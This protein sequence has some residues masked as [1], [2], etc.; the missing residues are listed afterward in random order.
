MT[1]TQKIMLTARTALYGDMEASAE[2]AHDLGV[3]PRTVRNW[4]AGKNDVPPE[5]LQRVDA[6][7]TARSRVLK[8]AHSQIVALTIVRPSS[9]A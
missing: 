4:I 2:F 7:L 3:N 9:G 5:V 6:L 8:D 1:R